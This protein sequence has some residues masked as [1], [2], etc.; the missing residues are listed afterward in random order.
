MRGWRPQLGARSRRGLIHIKA[1]T[2]ASRYSWLTT[3]KTN[4]ILTYT[5][6]IATLFLTGCGKSDASA[7][8]KASAPAP[9]AA[10]T[11]TPNNGRAITFTANDAMKFNIVELRAT[12]GEALAVTL[13]NLGTMPKFS[14]GHNWVLLVQGTN[15]EDF[16]AA[17]AEAPTTDYVPAKF[18]DAIVAHTKLLGPNESDTVTFNAPTTPGRHIFLCSFPGHF[19]VGMKGVLIIE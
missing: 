16:V 8:A 19:Q 2:A 13:K 10:A 5:I 11:N 17:G 14:M 15:P 3:M 7:P 9:A 1:P 4:A 18:K 12:P 6:A